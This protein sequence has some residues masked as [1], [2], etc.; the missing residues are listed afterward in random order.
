MNYFFITKIE[1]IENEILCGIKCIQPHIT[2]ASLNMNEPSIC[3][4]WVYTNI[5]EQQI[6]Q[7]FEDLGFG[8]IEKIDIKG[9]HDKTGNAPTSNKVFVHLRW[10]DDEQTTRVR[11]NLTAGQKVKIVYDDPWYW[12]ISASTSVRPEHY[13]P[14]TK[15]VKQ[16]PYIDFDAS[17]PPLPPGPPPPRKVKRVKQVKQEQEQ[18]HEEFNDC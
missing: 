14:R 9:K 17:R 2:M 11:A 15:Q 12:M 7:V 1:K 8:D 4:P 10:N 13:T 16:A 3:I 5:S 18:G 6:A